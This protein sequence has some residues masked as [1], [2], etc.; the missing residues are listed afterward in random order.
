MLFALLL[1]GTP[2]MAQYNKDNLRVETATA[3]NYRYDKLQLFPIRA[4]DAFLN[5]HKDLGDYVTLKEAIEKGKVVISEVEQG[6]VNTLYLE[7]IS[8]DTVMILS[9]E[10]VKGGKQ[11]R[12]IAQDVILH[13]GSGKKDVSVFCVEHGRWQSDKGNM[14]FDGYY[15]ISS[16]SIRKAGAV[17]KNQSEVWNKVS[18][19]TEKNAAS[20]S[21]G[22][23]A[24]L[25]NSETFK[26][27]LGRYTRHFNT[28]LANEN[29]VIGVVAVSGDK[30]M[31]CD[32]FATHQLFKQHY[33]NLINSYATEAITSGQ[34]VTI[35]PEE[36]ET[37]LNRIIEDEARQESEV[38][39]Q[40][41]IL[42]EK[43]KKLHMSV[44]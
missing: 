7:N 39:K 29:N 38:E 25:Q 3:N 20:T 24:A 34:A 8:R 26:N 36:V 18:E 22:T 23:L 42:K 37:F 30:I 14:H 21:T 15:T 41:T 4:N 17:N 1:L 13:P 32:M 40:G 6:T 19:T 9:G 10:V 43:N 27:E 12:M 5:S 35:R 33:P 11:D 44:F 31:G 28:I 16:N 2:L